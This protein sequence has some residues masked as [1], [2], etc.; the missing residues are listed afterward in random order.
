MPEEHRPADQGEPVGG[1]RI[2]EPPGE[3]KRKDS[4]PDVE[5]EGEHPGALPQRA[6]DVRRA[7]VPRTGLPQV[8][9]AVER[10][11]DEDAERDGAEQVAE[12]DEQ[13]AAEPRSVHGGD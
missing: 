2:E 10:L 5:Q 1:G 9:R 8:Q 11:R 12:E 13:G 6:R 7:D 4:F 3:R